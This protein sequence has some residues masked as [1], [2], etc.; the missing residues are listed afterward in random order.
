MDGCISQDSDCFLYGAKVVYRN[1]CTVTN[2]TKA[3]SGGSIDEYNMDKIREVL[4]I[5]RNKMIALALICGCDYD[6][7]LSGVGKEAALKL[8]KIVEDEEILKRY[9]KNK[10]SL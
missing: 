7:G 2:G 1:F 9:I 3:T 5:G 10:R 4:N 8:F 6:D